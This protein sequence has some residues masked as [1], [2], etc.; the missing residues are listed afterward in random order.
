MTNSIARGRFRAHADLDVADRFRARRG[1]AARRL[2]IDEL[3]TA[4]STPTYTELLTCLDVRRAEGPQAVRRR[5]NAKA[6]RQVFLEFVPFVWLLVAA[7]QQ[8]IQTP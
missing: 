2:W 1:A 5:Q 8:R 7:G 6:G 4:G 3:A